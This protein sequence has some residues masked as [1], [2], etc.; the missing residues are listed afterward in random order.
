MLCRVALTGLLFLL[1]PSSVPPPKVGD[2]V[3]PKDT[4]AVGAEAP[5]VFFPE[6]TELAVEQ[7]LANGT[8]VLSF[9]IHVAPG[10]LP[11]LFRTKAQPFLRRS[12]TVHEKASQ[13]PEPKD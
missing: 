7:I 1:G 9:R 5:H 12:Y 8:V 10:Q 4:I 11:R 6:D 13:T 3:V 2:V